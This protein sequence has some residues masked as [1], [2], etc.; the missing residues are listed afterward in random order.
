MKGGHFV[1]RGARAK[2]AARNNPMLPLRVDR[3]RAAQ[4]L[5][6]RAWPDIARHLGTTH[7]RL[8]H[9]TRAN[10]PIQRRCRRK[11]RDG[12]VKL[13]DVDRAWLSGETD[14]LRYVV[15]ADATTLNLQPSVE[16]RWS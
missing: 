1:A 5:D 9:L 16:S 14:A 7:P 6:G 11:L 3:L 8:F 15:T 10:G 13:F 2:G 4:Q 12:F